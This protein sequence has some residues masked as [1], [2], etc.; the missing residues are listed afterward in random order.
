MASICAGQ[1]NHQRRTC[2]ARTLVPHHSYSRS[3]QGSECECSGTY[4]LLSGCPPHLRRTQRKYRHKLKK[5][6]EELEE[7]A[8]ARS[9]SEPSESAKSIKKNKQ[10]SNSPISEFR[11]R[12]SDNSQQPSS[13]R[14]LSTTA[15]AALEKSK[16]SL[17]A[18][19]GFPDCLSPSHLDRQDQYVNCRD[20]FCELLPAPSPGPT[21]QFFAPPEILDAPLEGC[22]VDELDICPWTTAYNSL[23]GACTTPETLDSENLQG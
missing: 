1:H 22:Y 5:R 17:F 21:S 11:N 15:P 8:G 2:Q 18:D 14:P 19:T 20:I 7:L 12:S 4:V 6:L 16:T 10:G 3:A 9:D 23:L 13:S